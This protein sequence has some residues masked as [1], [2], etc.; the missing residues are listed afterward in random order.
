MEEEKKKNV[1]YN[2]VLGA[3]LGLFISFVFWAASNGNPWSFILIP[4]GSLIAGAQAYL[5]PERER[6]KKR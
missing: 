5:M 6:K 1:I 2:M 4:A 3:I